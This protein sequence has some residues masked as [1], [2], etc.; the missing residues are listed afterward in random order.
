MIV[1][2]AGVGIGF[3]NGMAATARITGYARGLQANGHDVLVLC[4]GTSEAS[5]EAAVNTQ[6]QGISAGVRFEYA[7]GSTVR[8]GSFCRRRTRRMAGLMGAA[9]LVCR[10]QTAGQVEAILLYSQ[11]S[12]D[13]SVLRVVSR[14]VGAVFLTDVSEIPY[15]S[16]KP[17]ILEKLRLTIYERTF[18]RWFDAAV[19]ISEPL[20]RHVVHFGKLGVAVCKAPVI[21]DTDEFKPTRPVSGPQPRIVMYSGGLDH[22]KDGVINLLEAFRLVAAEVPDCHLTLVGDA[23]TGTRVPQ[24]RAVAEKLEISDRVTFT[25]RVTRHEMPRYLAQ[26][27]VL[28]LARPQSSQ[29]EAGMPTKVA[30]YL[31]SGVPTV[32]TR[33]GDMPGFLEDGVS[34]YLVPP[35][36]VPALAAAV[37]HVLLNSEEGAAVG[38]R[39]RQVAL[40]YFDYRVVGASIAAFIADLRERKELG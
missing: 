26:A 15:Q 21:V 22:A 34:A 35:G 19:V 33:T 36:D 10:E 24:F 40:D 8:S 32:L 18:Y 13:A 17:R 37:R 16:P 2:V 14:K 9:R 30:E 20:R 6:V 5:A 29:A 25:G 31:A 28:V 11:R 1:I 12:L 7:C 39:G 23:P 3:P 4:L 38:D 27:S